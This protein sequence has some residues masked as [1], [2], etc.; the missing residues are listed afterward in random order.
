MNGSSDR[1]LI[2]SFKVL[3]VGGR[4]MVDMSDDGLVA[5]V[6]K[7]Y[8]TVYMID[9]LGRKSMK[10]LFMPFTAIVALRITP[11]GEYLVALFAESLFVHSIVPK[12]QTGVRIHYGGELH[13]RRDST[14]MSHDSES[15]FFALKDNSIKTVRLKTGAISA[16]SMEN[17]YAVTCMALS[18][19]DSTLIACYMD[20]ITRL[21]DVIN[22][23]VISSHEFPFKI[24]AMAAVS[25]KN[26]FSMLTGRREMFVWDYKEDQVS[27]LMREGVQISTKYHSYDITSDNR[28]IAYPG[29]NDCLYLQDTQ[30]YKVNLTRLR[31]YY[32]FFA[33]TGDGSK[34]I[35]YDKYTISVYTT[36][37]CPFWSQMKHLEFGD[38]DELQSVIHMLVVSH[39]SKLS[40]Y[41]RKRG[42]EAPRV[43]ILELPKEILFLVLSFLRRN[44]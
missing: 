15:V 22:N 16:V 24:Y 18:L 30:S 40:C 21:Y 9:T 38:D 41:K 3:G 6:G 36:N 14:T 4:M 34:L 42:M 32:P 10:T 8:N 11:N 37:I 28:M 26:H 17:G 2:T 5:I 13:M 20:G 23:K 19:D 31:D 35:Y 39:L 1:Y 29:T 43:R 25:G 44:V 27:K 33:F 12:L 7:Q